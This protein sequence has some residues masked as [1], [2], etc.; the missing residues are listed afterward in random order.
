MYSFSYLDQKRPEMLTPTVAT[1]SLLLLAQFDNTKG[2]NINS[3]V[4]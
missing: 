1:L 4:H 3:C 2:A